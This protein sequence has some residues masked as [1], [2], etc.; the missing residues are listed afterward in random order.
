[1][2]E[3]KI[4]NKCK[5]EKPIELFSFHSGANYRRSECKLCTN[6]LRKERKTLKKTSPIIPKN[7]T[8]PIC[9]K[10]ENELR[11]RGGKVNPAFVL[12]HDHI[13]KKFRGYICQSCN[14]ALGTFHTIELLANA[15]L[16]LEKTA[17]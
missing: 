10:V 14:R 16:Y 15:I 13:T 11:G 2:D 12:D 6:S 4:C 5:L 17:N 9:K 8:C 7:H 3:T 1:M